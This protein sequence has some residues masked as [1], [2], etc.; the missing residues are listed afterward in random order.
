MDPEHPSSPSERAEHLVKLTAAASASEANELA[1][2]LR[3]HGIV[4]VANAEPLPR[5][6]SSRGILLPEE[7]LPVVLVLATELDRALD[8]LESEME[9]EGDAKRHEI[10]R[11]LLE[12]EAE[13][14]A[15]LDQDLPD[16]PIEPSS[17][18]VFFQR[19][20]RITVRV[21]ITLVVAL[22]AFIA[23]RLVQRMR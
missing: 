13:L 3:R 11:D 2:Q 15:R 12:A 19:V 8:F 7:H 18:E 14:D 17:M 20:W 22:V 5:R 10:E 4:A 16:E 6:R 9:A 23:W 1:A 21:G